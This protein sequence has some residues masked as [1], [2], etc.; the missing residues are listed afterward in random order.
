MR[1]RE[2]KPI[3]REFVDAKTQQ[4]LAALDNIEDAVEE[5][6]E[7]ATQANRIA[8]DLLRKYSPLAQQ[9]P[10]A[11]RHPVV[12][13]STQQPTP[14]QKSEPV[15]QSAP[16]NKS[17]EL[18]PGSPVQEELG[19]TPEIATTPKSATS[20]TTI[21]ADQALIQIDQFHQTIERLRIVH[22]NLPPES[23]EQ[24]AVE[25]EKLKE[26]LPSMINSAKKQ[27]GDEKEKEIIGKAEETKKIAVSVAKKIGMNDAWG[28]ELNGIMAEFK[29]NFGQTF[30]QHIDNGTTLKQNWESIIDTPM[31]KVTLQDIVNPALSELFNPDNNEAFSILKNK[32]LSTSV[33]PGQGSGPGETILALLIPNSKKAGKGDL[34][35]NDELWEIKGGSYNSEGNSLKESGAW[36]DC[37]EGVK[38]PQLRAAFSETLQK[39]L[40]KYWNKKIQV[41]SRG[42]YT[43]SDLAR[44]SDFRPNSIWAMHYLLNQIKMDARYHVIEEV[45]AKYFPSLKKRYP[46]T[47]D[48]AIT[49]T[50]NAIRLQDTDDKLSDIHA[51]L[52]MMEYMFGAYKSKGIIV[53]NKTTDE[54]MVIQGIKGINAS[55]TSGSLYTKTMTLQGGGDAKAAPGIFLATDRDKIEAQLG[56]KRS[57]P[58]KAKVRKFIESN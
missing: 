24:L 55:L 7:I 37:T 29:N 8:Q 43:L 32:V 46:K 9:K 39:Y 18:P 50:L 54:L 4:S 1:F 17:Q 23:R 58:F 34:R 35:I 28:K 41:G 40:G 44:I 14:V 22:D 27:G 38:A 5:N 11:S 16:V 53:F 12:Q 45:Y 47:F 10:Q 33:G 30:L 31:K 13:K 42:T 56:I 26:L 15:Q 25:I 48:S 20:G 36:L 21:T 2:I 51:K 3:L 52:A 19:T 6:P 49:V 57:K